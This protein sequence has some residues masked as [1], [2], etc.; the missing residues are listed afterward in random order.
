MNKT[1]KK[2]IKKNQ[3][4]KLLFRQNQINIQDEIN[5]EKIKEFYNNEHQIFL[6]NYD[7]QLINLLFPNS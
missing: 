6:H 3:N 1:I 4:K 2:N 7:N 5:R